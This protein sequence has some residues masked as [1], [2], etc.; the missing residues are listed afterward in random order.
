MSNYF[1][2]V[3]IIKTNNW[4]SELNKSIK[5]LKISAPIIVTTPGNRN[6]LSLDSKFD[7]Q[8]IFSDFG[9]NPNFEDCINVIEFCQ[10]NHLNYC[11]SNV[12]KYV[13]RHRNKNGAEDIRKAIHNLELLLDLEYGET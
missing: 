5:N 3:K 1:N 8:S 6:R 13:C 2:P 11:E 7:P 10:K 4:Q 12:I 9:S